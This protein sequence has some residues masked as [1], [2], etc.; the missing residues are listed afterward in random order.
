MLTTAEVQAHQTDPAI[1]SGLVSGDDVAVAARLSELLTDVALV[2]LS[3][4]AA[5][6]AP[7]IRAKLEDHAA[8]PTSPLRS[9]CLTALDLMRGSF[10]Q[11]FDSIAYAGMLDA[12]Q[13]GGVVSQAERDEL[14]AL[15]I[16]PR[17]VTA[18]EVAK[19][20]RNDDGSS[21]L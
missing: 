20:I 11:N 7:S 17:L 10:A 15:A 3:T 4:L 2:P 14:T 13:A 12:L 21:K 9:L 1:A 19:A 18:N 16:K 6:A 8:E 5:W